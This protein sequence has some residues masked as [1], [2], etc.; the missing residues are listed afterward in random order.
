MTMTLML[1]LLATLQSAA[2]SF[3][4]EA[5]GT[6]LEWMTIA[7]FVVPAILCAALVY[8]GTKNTVR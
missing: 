6:G 1:S 3:N 7:A 8:I 5:T 4:T 2:S